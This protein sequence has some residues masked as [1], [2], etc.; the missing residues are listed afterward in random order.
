MM[1]SHLLWCGETEDLKFTIASNDLFS[2]IRKKSRVMDEDGSQ[3]AVPF[4]RCWS[5]LLTGQ[6][7]KQKGADP[8]LR[9]GTPRLDSLVMF[10]PTLAPS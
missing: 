9:P 3:Q 6:T 7:K 1:C 5:F 2:H 10:V 8:F 4:E